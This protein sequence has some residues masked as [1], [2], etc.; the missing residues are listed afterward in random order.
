MG[1]NEYQKIIASVLG[2]R[3]I[4]FDRNLA[5]VLGSAKAGLFLSQ[6]LFWWKKG[7]NPNWVYKT[8]K[9]IE[10]ETALSRQEQDTAIKICKGFG[11]LEVRLMGIPAKRHFRLNINKIVKL[12][13]ANL[14]KT[15]KQD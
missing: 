1:R 6:L 10:D 12:L 15:S 13:E 14:P 7:R 9:E 5:K 8:I 2:T 11:A 3:P 4:F